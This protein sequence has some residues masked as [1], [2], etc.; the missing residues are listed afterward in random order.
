MTAKHAMWA[1][2]I[3]NTEKAVSSALTV[4]LNN[5]WDRCSFLYFLF[6]DGHDDK[7]HLWQTCHAQVHTQSASC[8]SELSVL[9]AL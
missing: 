6:T 8:Q 5:L 2:L 7:Q 9:A 4:C 1:R 3:G